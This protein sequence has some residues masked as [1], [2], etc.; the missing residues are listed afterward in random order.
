[1][2]IAVEVSSQI[3]PMDR[4]LSPFSL[5]KDGTVGTA[6]GTLGF[7]SSASSHESACPC[8]HQD[9]R[10]KGGGV[11]GSPPCRQ[12]SRW[13][14]PE[15]HVRYVKGRP[16]VAGIATIPAAGF[17]LVAMVPWF[18]NL[19]GAQQTV[20]QQSQQTAAQQAAGN[21]KEPSAVFSVAVLQC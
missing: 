20:V 9:L 2:Y 17:V 12:H 4:P 16:T 6:G 19:N 7:R 8:T 3:V 14:A 21:N 18:A 5:A 15:R 11:G 13:L 1:M 10:D